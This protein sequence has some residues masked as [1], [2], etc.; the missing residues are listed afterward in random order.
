MIKELIDL[1]RN[2]KATCTIIETSE[3][4]LL[5]PAISIKASVSD[6]FLFAGEKPAFADKLN[7]KCGKTSLCYFVITEI[8]EISLEKQERFI[9][10]VKDREING[11]TLP[12][13]CVI[14]FTVK[15]KVALKNLSKDLYHFAVV[16][17]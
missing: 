5:K 11:Y 13:N 1:Q 14:V 15:D 2:S 9:G 10:L 6:K 12:D 3:Y 16:A 17:F 8:D 4:K 7:E